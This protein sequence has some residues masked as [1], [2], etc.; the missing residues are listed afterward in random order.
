MHK[1]F[2]C[3]VELKYKK[4]LVSCIQIE[5]SLK[6]EWEQCQVEVVRMFSLFLHFKF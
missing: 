3:T 1:A 6:I 2:L 5:N 4:S